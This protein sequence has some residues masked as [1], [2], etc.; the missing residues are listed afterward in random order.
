MSSTWLVA[1]HD[2]SVT[3]EIITVDDEQVTRIRKA[4][5]R[6]R[7]AKAEESADRGCVRVDRDVPANQPSH[8]INLCQRA[9]PETGIQVWFVRLF[10]Q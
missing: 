1:G 8:V 3:G 5:D 9:S 4:L 6:T 10:P 7:R 2:Y